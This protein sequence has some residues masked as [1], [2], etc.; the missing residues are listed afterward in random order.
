M[1]LGAGLIVAGIGPR[2]R[3]RGHQRLRRALC[4][5]I[6][7]LGGLFALAWGIFAAVRSSVF[8]GLLALA[9]LAVAFGGWRA[10]FRSPGDAVPPPA[11]FSNS[12][13]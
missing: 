13:E 2:S 11:D 12:D 9:G 4:G 6:V 1:A 5:L 7:V 3:D 8:F 10:G